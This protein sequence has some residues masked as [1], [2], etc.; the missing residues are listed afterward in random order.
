MAAHKQEIL[1]FQPLY[2]VAAWFQRQYLRFWGWGIPLSY[3]RHW[4]MQAEVKIIQDGGSQTEN[5]Y[6]STIISRSCI[7]PTTIS[8]F[9]RL[10]NS[11][12]LF[13]IAWDSRGNEKSKMAA[14]KQRI[15]ISQP[16]LPRTSIIPTTIPMF[17]RM[18]NSNKLFRSCVV[19]AG[20]KNSRWRLT[21]R[22]YWYFN[23][24]I[25]LLHDFNDNIYVFEVEVFH[26]AISDIVWCKRE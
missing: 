24:Y 3:F 17:L 20:V 14:H 16:V 1:I 10:W 22:K 26:W 5:T 7:N 4:V 8:T 23:H 2:H 9:L 12:E 11:T 25:M 21:N 6:I 13:L 19:Q 18:M 15:L